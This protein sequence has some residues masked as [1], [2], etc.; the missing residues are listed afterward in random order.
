[1]N[2]L[3]SFLGAISAPN[4]IWMK[5][6]SWVFSWTKSWGWAIFVFAAL[7][8]LV[9]SPLDFSMKLS[10]KK[11]SL[12]Q[13]KCSPEIAKLEKKFGNDKQRLQ[14]QKQQLYKREGL[15]MG[16]G[17]IVMLL[18]LILTFTIYI[19]FYG[20]LRQ[21][22]AYTVID[23]YEKVEEAY[24]EAL[25]TKLDDLDEENYFSSSY[26]WEG[27]ESWMN[28][29]L[30]LS[31][32]KLESEQ[33]GSEVVFTP[34]EETE[35]TEMETFY[36]QHYRL[37]GEE[38]EDLMFNIADNY[39]ITVANEKW[40]SLRS[41]WLWIGNIWVSDSPIPEFANYETLV[42]TANNGSTYYSKYVSTNISKS[43]YESISSIMPKNK[44]GYYLVAI[45]SGLVTFLSQYI[46]ELHTKLKNKKANKVAKATN[47]QSA[48]SMK[49]MKIILPLINVIF[50]LSTTA[51]FGLYIL[52]SN[53]ITIISGEII[54]LI[55][56]KITKKKRLEV[57]SFLEKEADRMIRKG[58]LSA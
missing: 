27:A 39:A 58:K 22:S 13:Q 46:T 35:L 37:A 31:Q 32:K 4:N 36:N 16:T 17:C 29:F 54:T 14:L 56:D 30:E 10:T 48:G 5:A 33:E 12:V 21:V 55:V 25:F 19:S 52:A 38:G 18:N 42:K 40:Q 1:M 11:Q 49:T 28:R 26:D 57:E 3:F 9:L 24:D 51:S 15:N 45:L 20:A 43:E 6:I 34:E 7:L 2:N 41:N 50:V 53:I 23:Q 8:K 44:N 47:A